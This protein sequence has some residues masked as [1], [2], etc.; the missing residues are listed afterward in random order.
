MKLSE[1]IIDNNTEVIYFDETSFHSRL[2]QRKAWW[3]KG[4]RLKIPFTENRG[5]GFTCMGALS[6]C[7][8]NNSYF[9]IHKSTKGSCVINFMTNI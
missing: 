3:M 4:E 9:E 1:F 5:E 8:K 6:K 2:V 7:L